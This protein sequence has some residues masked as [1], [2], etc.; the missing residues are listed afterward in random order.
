[1]Y[2]VC[3]TKGYIQVGVFE[4]ISYF[5]FKW[6]VICECYPFFGLLNHCGWEFFFVLFFD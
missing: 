1:M 4:E 6:T 3:G 2:S 5:P